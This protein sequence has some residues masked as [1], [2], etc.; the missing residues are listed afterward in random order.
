MW[1]WGARPYCPRHLPASFG[2]K[3]LPC[4]YYHIPGPW[5]PGALWGLAGPG[6][7]SLL[8]TWTCRAAMETL[9]VPC[10]LGGMARGLLGR[11]HPLHIR[12]NRGAAL[13]KADVV[14]LAGGLQPPP[15]LFPFPHSRTPLTLRSWYSPALPLPLSR[16]LNNSEFEIHLNSC[17]VVAVC[18]DPALH[19]G[20]HTDS[21]LCGT[22]CTAFA[23]V[24][25]IQ[26]LSFIQHVHIRHIH[27]HIKCFEVCWTHNTCIS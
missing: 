7:H 23:F 14:L 8:L 10:F 2:E 3:P 12:Q 9:G 19:K 24:H 1:C 16:L 18:C 22:L 6:P 17:Q 21:G 13:K 27:F 4:L 20:R 25:V 5:S 15:C 26:H 11:N